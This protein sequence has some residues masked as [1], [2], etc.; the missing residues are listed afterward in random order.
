MVFS[1]CG[2]VLLIV[3]SSLCF[4]ELGSLL[5]D[6]GNVSELCLD[7]LRQLINLSDGGG[8]ACYH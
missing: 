7:C 2:A 5:S 6:I 1:V 4:P 3:R 8:A